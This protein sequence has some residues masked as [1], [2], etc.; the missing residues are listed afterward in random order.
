MCHVPSPSS[1]ALETSERL[2]PV[3]GNDAHSTP[4]PQI[5]SMCPQHNSATDNLT[6]VKRPSQRH[7]SQTVL[8]MQDHVEITDSC[9]WVDPDLGP[10]LMFQFRTIVSAITS[11]PASHDARVEVVIRLHIGGILNLSSHYGLSR[12]RTHHV[13][14]IWPAD[15]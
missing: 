5:S 9:V 8:L 1:H 12:P 13:H 3:D 4:A 6:K 2:C 11:W 10:K 15:T 7:S 14:R